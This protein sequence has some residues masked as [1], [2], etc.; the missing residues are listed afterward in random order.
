LV[1]N[2]SCELKYGNIDT[3]WGK[4]NEAKALLEKVISFEKQTNRKEKHNPAAFFKHNKPKKYIEEIENNMLMS[5]TEVACDI[6][7]KMI[8]K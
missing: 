6:E 5:N 4:Y 8:V 1:D 7:D 2:D 3:I